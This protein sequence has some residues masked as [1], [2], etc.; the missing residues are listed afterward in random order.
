MKP[1]NHSL[2]L[3]QTVSTRQPFFQKKGLI[4]KIPQKIKDFLGH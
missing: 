3:L 1:E 4:K 2:H